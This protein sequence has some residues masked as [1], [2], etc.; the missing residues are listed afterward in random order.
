MDEEVHLVVFGKVHMHLAKFYTFQKSYLSM[1]TG[2]FHIFWRKYFGDTISIGF[3]F[4]ANKIN[5]YSAI[6]SLFSYCTFINIWYL[7][8]ENKVMV[9][10]GKKLLHQQTD[11]GLPA[12]RRGTYTLQYMLMY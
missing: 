12:Q 10:T 3:F 4:K 8:Q 7:I 11:L 9:R 2:L 6:L 5:K 1:V